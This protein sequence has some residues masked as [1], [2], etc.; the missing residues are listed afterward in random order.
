[1]KS[2]LSV[3]WRWEAYRTKTLE[4][5]FPS[6][7]RESTSSIWQPKTRRQK[8]VSIEKIIPIRSHYDYRTL[9]RFIAMIQ[10]INTDQ[11]RFHPTYCFHL[12]DRL[13]G[14][15]VILIGWFYLNHIHWREF[16]RLKFFA[17]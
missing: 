17:T 6:L 16:F 1:M 15:Y 11:F 10:L 3:E 7:I 14:I 5:F 9:C 2:S 4:A 8:S 13:L 12:F